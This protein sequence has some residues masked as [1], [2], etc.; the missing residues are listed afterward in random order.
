M[1]NWEQ[2]EK[3]AT[4]VI[5]LKGLTPR[6]KYL[7]MYSQNYIGD[8]AIFRLAS[9]DAGKQTSTFYKYGSALAFPAD[10]LYSLFTDSR[11][12]RKDLLYYRPETKTGK[13]NMKYYMKDT[14][15]PKKGTD[16]FVLR[17][18][19]MYLIRA[20]AFMHQNLPDKAISD[21]KTLEAR[22]LGISP[23]EVVLNYAS[24]EDVDRFIEIER[25]KE[26][27]FEGHRFF[28]IAR[29]KKDVIREK[30]TNS[31]VRRLVYPDYRFAL[32]IPLVEKEANPEIQQNEGY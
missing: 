10:T 24:N 9:Y 5:N 18:S 14:S 19:E 21:V 27:C 8:E 30:A 20:E 3:L 4:E 31:N 2:A 22:A 29:Q 12:I 25:V 17:A 6:D 15:D 23:S 32:P 7:S 16:I 11:D 26:L 1:E 13:V 28:D